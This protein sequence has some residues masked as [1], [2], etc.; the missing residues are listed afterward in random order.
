MVGR[1]ELCVYEQLSKACAKQINVKFQRVALS[2]QAE[3]DILMQIC[4]RP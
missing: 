2:R 1:F 4:I 3:Q